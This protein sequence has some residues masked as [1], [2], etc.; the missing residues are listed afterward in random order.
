[1]SD[2][3]SDTQVLTTAREE[4]AAYVVAVRAA[5]ADLPSDEVDDLTGGLEADL[6]EQLAER[7]GHLEGAL[8]TPVAYAAELRSAAGLPAAPVGSTRTIDVGAWWSELRGELVSLGTAQPWLAS[9][10]AFCRTLRPAWWVLRGV[11]VAA[12]V[13]GALGAGSS[14][15][16]VVLLGLPFAVA[17]VL[18]GRWGSSGHRG[19]VAGRQ[20]RVVLVLVNVVVVW[21]GAAAL[22]GAG[23][24]SS[25]VDSSYAPPYPAGLSVDGEPV[26]NLYVYDAEGHRLS[27]VRVFDDRGRSVVLD[28]TV[29]PATGQ[30]LPGRADVYGQWWTNVFPRPYVVGGDP[31]GRDPSAD[32]SD[33]A[34]AGAEQWQAPPSVAPLAPASASTS[35]PTSAPTSAST[36]APT[37]SVTSAP[38]GSGTRTAAPTGSATGPATTSVPPTSAVTTTR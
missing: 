37:G 32:P 22:A 30:T 6:G 3:A 7:G 2:E 5:L 28:R 15:G 12:A 34:Y 33:P 18:L 19:R 17:S 24:G 4:V 20:G 21:A 36:S 1:M 26:G 11:L 13:V 25:Y 14:V 23:D 29:D 10:W 35:A 8:G 9:A 27:D 38:T 31:Y 16:A